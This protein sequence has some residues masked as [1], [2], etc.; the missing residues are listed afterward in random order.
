MKTPAKINLFLKVTGHCENSYHSL[1]TL[2][3]PLAEPS[4]EIKIDF[5]AA[6]GIAIN[7]AMPGVPSDK[8]NLCWK[9]AN[10]YAAL[11]GMSPDWRISIEKNIPAAAGMGG[12]SSD[13]AAVLRIL[14]RHYRKLTDEELAATARRCGADVPF[15]LSPRPALASGIGDIL[16]YPE[17]DFPEIP[18]LLINPGFPIPAAWAYNNLA[19]KDIGELSADT[20]QNIL[21]ALRQ[22]DLEKLSALIFNDL[23]AAC[24]RKFPLLKTLKTELL[25]AGAAA[26]ISGSGPTIFALCGTFEKR[27]ELTAHFSEKYPQMTVIKSKLK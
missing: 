10:E 12:G 25:R 26:E 13:A 6:P 3:L 24:C 15:F 1:R 4:D 27:D 18:L 17:I 21:D 7:C 9:A 14:N 22:G 23:A 8:R 5:A 11:A 16:E 20:E 19:T 2:F